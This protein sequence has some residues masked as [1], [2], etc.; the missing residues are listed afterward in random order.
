MTDSPDRRTGPALCCG[1]SLLQCLRRMEWRHVLSTSSTTSSR[2]QAEVLGCRRY[3][4]SE[5]VDLSSECTH[6]QHQTAAP[7]SSNGSSTNYRH[8]YVLLCHRHI[9]SCFAIC[10]CSRSSGG[11][12]IPVWAFLIEPAVLGPAVQYLQHTTAA[13]E[14]ALKRG[15]S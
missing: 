11:V 8:R 4:G 2:L 5:G 15:S 7:N 10:N 1:L 12:M 6:C 3:L 14:F 9:Y 13:T